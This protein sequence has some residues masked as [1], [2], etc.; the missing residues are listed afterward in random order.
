MLSTCAM[1]PDDFLQL[2]LCQDP[3]PADIQTVYNILRNAYGKAH[4]MTELEDPD[5]LRIAYHINYITT[6][7]VQLMEALQSH[8]P[9]PLA[10]SDDWLHE[11]ATLFGDLVNKLRG[12]QLTSRLRFDLL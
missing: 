1:L 5:P 10:L 3:W 9:R 4:Q 11:A 2:P 8:S 7:V 6:D 12:S